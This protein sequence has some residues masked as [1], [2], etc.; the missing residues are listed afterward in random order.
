ML[1]Y[2]E[3][4]KT[5]N[6][7]DSMENERTGRILKFE[8]IREKGNYIFQYLE[9]EKGR[10]LSALWHT[11]D[12]FE[13]MIVLKGENVHN[14]NNELYKLHKDDIFLLAPGEYH[15]SISQSDDVTAICLS[16]ERSE[17]ERICS[18]FDLDVENEY[19]KTAPTIYGCEGITERIYTLFDNLETLSSERDKRLLLS[20]LI[21]T[22]MDNAKLQS[23]TMP[24]WLADALKEMNKP[25]NMKEGVAALL[26]IS[27]YS[28]SRLSKLVWK[29][30]GLSLHDYVLK[31]RLSAAHKEIVL[32]TKDI[33][34]IAEEVGYASFSHFQKIFKKQYGVTPAKLRARHSTFTI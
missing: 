3:R 4:N 23:V 20:L 22:Y 21:K 24:L 32:S 26:R 10:K 25:E 33:E 13:W 6:A 30:L 7:G 17:F 8:K 15:D 16:V 27:N 29:H 28:R 31:L 11:H 1:C 34:Q 14:I 12:F 9:G 2:N 19:Q 5:G 18:A